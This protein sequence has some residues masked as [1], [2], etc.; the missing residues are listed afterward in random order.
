MVKL[1]FREKVKVLVFEFKIVNQKETDRLFGSQI[2][3]QILY[4]Y[5]YLD[6]LYLS[7]SYSLRN[8]RY[9]SS[10]SFQSK[11]GALEG[12]ELDG[13]VKDMMEPIKVCSNINVIL[14]II[15]ICNSSCLSKYYITFASDSSYKDLQAREE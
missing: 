7:I 3:I 9:F 14:N 12:A 6:R 2:H 13:F 10:F 5:E 15:I 4:E 8:K 1:G 11:T